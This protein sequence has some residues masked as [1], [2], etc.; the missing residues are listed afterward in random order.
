MPA[1]H[2]QIE[3][4]LGRQWAFITNKPT[5]AEA[6]EYLSTRAGYKYPYR[7]VRV[8]RTVVFEEETGRIKQ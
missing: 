3:A 7:V 8:V 4:K 5:L 1:K 2:F 6:Y